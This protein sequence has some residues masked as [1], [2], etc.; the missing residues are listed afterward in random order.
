MKLILVSIEIILLNYYELF[1]S[2]LSNEDNEKFNKF[3][4]TTFGFIIKMENYKLL[5]HVIKKVTLLILVRSP[6]IST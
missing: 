4:K 5:N 2:E 6:C 3:L 1:S